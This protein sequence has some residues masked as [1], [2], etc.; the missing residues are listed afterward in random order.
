MPY[1]S[2][3]LI[4]RIVFDGPA[5][6]LEVGEARLFTGALR[7]AVEVVTPE[8]FHETCEVPAE[9]AQ[10]DHLHTSALGGPTVQ[11]NG[12]AA[13]GFHNRWRNRSP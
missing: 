2:D 4:E 1:L 7:R 12:R 3:A 13:C 6:V 5:R 11:S 10:I 8:C 9:D